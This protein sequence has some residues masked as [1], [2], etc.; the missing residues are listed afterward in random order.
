MPKTPPSPPSP[1]PV[2]PSL[3][4]VLRDGPAPLRA[5]AATDAAGPLHIAFVG[6]G[7]T[8]TAARLAPELSALGHEV[9]RWP[10]ERTK[11]REWAGADVAVALGPRAAWRVQSLPDVGARALL[12]TADAEARLGASA[13]RTWTTQALRSGLLVLCAGEP[14]ADRIRER[15]G[16]AVCAY[17]PGV[18]LAYRSLPTHRRG[19]VVLL[20][21]HVE[22]PWRG[23]ALALL[24][25]RE[26]HDRRPEL[27]V[28][29]ARGP[30]P[31]SVPYDH[32]D[33][34]PDDD[35]DARA[36]AYSGSTVGVVCAT[37]G[38]DPVVAEMLA[39]GLPLVVLD[40]AARDAPPSL[41]LSAVQP[42]PLAIA[43]AVEGLVDDLAARAQASLSGTRWAAERTWAQ[44]AAGVERGLRQALGEAAA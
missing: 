21:A 34:G 32:L 19:D 23:A 11:L 1:V 36:L 16:A 28:A 39:C 17:V 9:T 40:E 6:P 2:P 8:T 13:A 42:D 26:L 27:Q 38:L 31:V 7:D 3:L 29:V 24:A 12:L 4:Q 30:R 44:A 37:D 35:A 33:L 41:G 22:L 25:G 15:H 10:R 20:D 43:D 14:L 18:D 5:P